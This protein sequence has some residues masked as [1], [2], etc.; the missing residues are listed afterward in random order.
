MFYRSHIQRIVTLDFETEKIRD[1]PNYPPKPVGLAVRYPDGERDYMAFAHDSG[2]NTTKSEVREWM[3]DVWRSNTPLLFF[4]AKFD[5]S[6]AY[7]KMGLPEL[8]WDRIHDAQFLAF[9]AD[10]HCRQLDLKSLAED[11]L[12]WPPETRDKIAEWVWAHRDK[13][14]QITGEKPKRRQGTNEASNAWAYYKHCP[15]PLVGDYGKDDVGMT[16]ELFEHLYPL[17]EKHGMCEAYDRERQVL[18]I[19]IEN[20][21][22]GIRV[23]LPNLEKDVPLFRKSLRRADKLLQ[24]RL[25]AKGLNIDADQQ[26]A[27]ALEDAGVID[28]DDWVYTA[29]TKRNPDGQ[30]SLSKDNLT[31]DMFADPEVGHLYFYRNRLKTFLDT[32]LESWLEQARECDGYTFTNWNQVRGVGG[33]TRTGRPSTTGNNFLNIPKKLKDSDYKID[34]RPNND[35]GL[36]SLPLVRWYMLADEGDV[37]MHRDFDGQEMRVFAH[38]EDGAL[39]RQYQADPKL[40]PHGWV[41]DEITNVTGQVLERTPVKTINFQ[42][43][44]GGG[45]PA[46]MKALGITRQKATEF[47]AFHH[48]ALPGLKMVNEAIEE[49]VREGDTIQTW[50]GRLYYPEEPKIIQ[51]RMRSSIYKLINYYCQGSAADITKEALIRWYYHPKNEARFLVTVYDEINSSAA[52][53]DWKR[54]MK[55]KREAMESIELDLKMTSSGKVGERWG[56]LEECD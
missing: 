19:F 48:K 56:D 33:G 40:D 8:G 20:E 32:F 30:R 25:G 3:L 35:Y 38:A 14:E 17:I 54:Q 53:G 21:Q 10:P 29:P 39:L 42:G 55:I 9:L 41:A 6:V 46:L 47:K 28:P 36:A 45:I 11:L 22:E 51:G 7:E 4:N 37:F 27:D 5:L 23:D 16:F 12:G 44:Y 31:L 52:K 15:V 1:R 49:I 2:N 50:G 13:L 43:V 26:F 18:P 24:G 34:M